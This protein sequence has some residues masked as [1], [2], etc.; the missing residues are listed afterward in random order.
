MVLIR[1]H[2][3]ACFEV[4]TSKGTVIVIDPH[5]GFSIG[6]KPPRVQADIVLITHEH[7]DHNA[8]AI[9]AKPN[10]KIL[11]MFIGEKTLDDIHIKG[12]EAYHDRERGR[13]RGRTSLYKIVVDNIAFVHLGDLGHELNEKYS[14]N[15]G[16]IDILMIPVGGTYTIDHRSAWSVI[17]VLKPKTVIPMHYWVKG[18]NLP[19]RP[20]EDFLSLKPDDWEYRKVETNQLNIDA[21]SIPNKV[22][23][24]LTLP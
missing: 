21:S 23:Y 24:V 20:V 10:A 22:I 3:H 19:L 5:D 11:S 17:E 14:K 13:R 4:V 15:F 2:G 1:W 9:V 18:L 16:S 12:V 6:L 8:Y 7:F